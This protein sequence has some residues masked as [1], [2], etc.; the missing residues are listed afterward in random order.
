[1]KQF[2]RIVPVVVVCTLCLII[3]QARAVFSFQGARAAASGSAP[4]PQQALMNQYCAGCHNQDD[5][6]GGMALDKLDFDKVGKDAATWERVVRKVRT[7]VSY[8]HLTLP[9]SDLV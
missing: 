9:T 2:R 4:N 3:A 8:T 5:N 6:A 1:M 7:A